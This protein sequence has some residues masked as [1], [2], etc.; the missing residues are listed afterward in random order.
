[1]GRRRSIF[2][3]FIFVVV[4]LS[5]GPSKAFELK[6][7]PR[8][9][10]GVFL[11]QFEQKPHLLDASPNSGFKLNSIMPFIQGGLT[12]YTGRVYLD[13]YA[14]KAFAGDDRDTITNVEDSPSVST[15]INGDIERQEY[16]ISAGVSFTDNFT[17]FAGWRT[18]TTSFDLKY[19]STLA[20]SMD[21]FEDKVDLD[22][23]G[24]FI[25]GA[26]H[27]SI[28]TQDRYI[29]L[30]TVNVAVGFLESVFILKSSKM[31]TSEGQTIDSQ[32]SLL[33]PAEDVSSDTMGLNVAIRWGGEIP[34]IEGFIYSLS[35]DGY[36]YT[37][38]PG[39]ENSFDY[40]EKAA[41][42]GVGLSYLL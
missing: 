33:E 5:P 32:E 26:G 31:I 10:S 11:Y 28:E 21:R 17:M 24:L 8:L 19:G 6:L 3:Y 1:M 18:S 13:F 9:N 38:S 15:T 25:G 7:I 16:S 34:K 40:A 20:G 29:G 35:A 2:L 12:L 27:L 22:Q 42:F 4:G 30:F 23:R 37:Y 41:R 14:Q 36:I 39:G